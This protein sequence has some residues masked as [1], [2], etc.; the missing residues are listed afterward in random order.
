[1]EL[2][3][4]RKAKSNP[5]GAL[6]KLGGGPWSILGFLFVITG[7]AILSYYGVIAGW[8]VGYLVKSIMGDLDP[9]GDVR[10]LHSTMLH[11]LGIDHNRFSVEYQGL[12]TKLTGVEPAAP[13]YDLFS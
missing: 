13:V 12:D 9:N 2:S 5:V 6:A 11:L 7:V 8:T 4:G 3:I 10:D 1:M